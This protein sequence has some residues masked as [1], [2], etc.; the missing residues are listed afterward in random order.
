MKFVGHIRRADGRI[1]L[2]CE[3]GCG[4]PSKL[5]QEMISRPW[6][7]HDGVHGCCGC[8]SDKSFSEYEKKVWA[9]NLKPGDI[10]NDCKGRNIKIKETSG[11]EG[12][13]VQL[14]LEDDSCCSAMNCCSPV[15]G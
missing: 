13:D 4:H 5:L 11:G 14:V 12:Y 8:C 15:E 1:E 6:K 10:V 9:T 3:H 7:R 2:T